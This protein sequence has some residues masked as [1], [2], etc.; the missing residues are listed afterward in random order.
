MSAA[1]RVFW[2][3]PQNEI[4][5]QPVNEAIGSKPCHNLDQCT[6]KLI[7][8][9][10]FHTPLQA[11]EILR[12][13]AEIPFKTLKKGSLLLRE[14]QVP[15]ACYHVFKGCVREYY[16][17]DGEEKTSE[18][19]LEGDSISDDLNKIERKPSRKYW[20]CLEDTTLSVFT[21]AQEE[22]MYRLFPRIESLC[23][24]ETEKKFGQFRELMAFYLASSPE[25]RYLNLLKTRPNLLTRVPQ[26]QL[27]SYLG[28]KPES[29]SRIRGRLQASKAYREDQK[30]NGVMLG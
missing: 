28:V 12:I 25:E 10:H 23:R 9:F 19:Y 20:E 21:Q 15:Q 30:G 4:A 13:V 8:D 5:M 18:F 3:I 26:Y 1:L 7:Q 16:L 14:G 11:E 22:K 6:D 17:V 29:L 27:A 24:I 2:P